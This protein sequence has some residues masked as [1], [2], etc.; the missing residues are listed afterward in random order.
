MNSSTKLALYGDAWETNARQDALYA[1]LSDRARRGT[2]DIDSFFAAGRAEIGSVLD[3]MRHAD[4]L[5][6]GRARFLDFG[7]GVGRN[8][9]ALMPHFAAGIGV[10]IS[11]S[12]VAKA[13]SHAGEDARAAEYVV[14]READLRFVAD[15][16]VDLVYSHIVLQHMPAALQRRYIGEFLRIL[17]PGGIAAFQTP[18][19]WR[20]RSLGRA[21]K[22]AMPKSLKRLY[23][24]ARRDAIRIEM[25]TLSAAAIRALCAAPGFEIIASPYTNS[26]DAAHAGVL[27]FMARAEAHARIRDGRADSDFLSQFFFV[28]RLPG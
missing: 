18:T 6:R 11:P 20:P 9:R 22:G 3:Y 21:V 2:W 23:H 7:C 10:D 19:G 13:R 8:T 26:T 14:N 17:A 12:M 5:P 16:S 27:A 1:V 15:G 25:H 24:A 4:A 28:R